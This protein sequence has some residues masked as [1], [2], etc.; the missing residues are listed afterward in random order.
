LSERF[1]G[2]NQNPLK[3]SE[4]LRPLDNLVNQRIRRN[5]TFRSADDTQ[6]IRLTGGEKSEAFEHLQILPSRKKSK[7]QE[8]DQQQPSNILLEEV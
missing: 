3:G 7:S 8:E 1:L 6:E 5:N 4:G 2:G